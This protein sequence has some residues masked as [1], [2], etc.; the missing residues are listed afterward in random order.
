MS[1]NYEQYHLILPKLNLYPSLSLN[2][3]EMIEQVMNGIILSSALNIEEII[4]KLI[5]VETTCGNILSKSYIDVINAIKPLCESYGILILPSEEALQYITNNYNNRLRYFNNKHID[6][7]LED[8]N[9]QFN[10]LK[11][12]SYNGIKLDFLPT[13][14]EW[15][16]DAVHQQHTFILENPNDKLMTELVPELTEYIQDSIDV[17]ESHTN[18]YANKIRKELILMK[19]TAT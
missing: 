15:I 2:S 8:I 14:S 7:K 16:Y 13:F 6:G 4:N 19:N 18:K 5:M 17:I 12:V 10:S 9:H 1:K 3:I 11:K